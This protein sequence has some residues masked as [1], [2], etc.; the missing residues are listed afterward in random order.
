M[1]PWVKIMLLAPHE[2]L[3][4]VMQLCE[5]YRARF[6]TM[7]NKNQISIAY[8]MP[9]SEMISEFF[10]NLKSVTSGY[11]SFDWEFLRYE[12]VEADKL[13]ILLNDGEVDEFSQVVVKERSIEKAMQLTKKLKDVIPRQQFEIKIQAKYKGKIIAAERISAFRKDVTA[14]LYGGDRTR[15]DKLLEKQKEGKKR[16]K[17]IGSV[18]V[19]KEAFLQLF[20]K[21]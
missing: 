5:S 21:S 12:E 17:M 10:D 6:I 7:D 2:Y 15:K 18:E 8:E 19:P 20:K 16:M 1:E 3:G 13:I 14:K 4:A 11:A 9:L